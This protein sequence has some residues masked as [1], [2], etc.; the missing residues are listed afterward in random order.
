MSSPRADSDTS[1]EQNDFSED[2]ISRVTEQACALTLALTCMRSA[3]SIYVESLRVCVCTRSEAHSVQSVVKSAAASSKES[4]TVH[5]C[6]FVSFLPSYYTNH[7]CN[8]VQEFKNL[9]DVGETVS[10]LAASSKTR[11]ASR[12]FWRRWTLPLEPNPCTKSMFDILYV[13]VQLLFLN[14]C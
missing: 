10:K 11:N 7:V 4:I 3:C 2:M 1:S 13:L 5:A 9:G 8:A 6:A 12:D 14:W